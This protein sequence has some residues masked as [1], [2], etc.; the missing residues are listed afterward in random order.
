M[1]SRVVTET[2][3]ELARPAFSVSYDEQAFTAFLKERP[4]AHPAFARDLLLVHLFAQGEP[5]AMRVLEDE[6]F[7]QLPIVIGSIDSRRGFVEDAVQETKTKLCA[8]R[9]L[10]QY[11]GR[12]PLAGWIRRA[13][14]NTA[15]VLKRP[16]Q[17]RLEGPADELLANDTELVY[18]KTRF[19]DAFRA[20]FRDAVTALPT[21][22]RTA[23]RLNAIANVSIDELGVMYQVHRATA[24]RWIQRARQDILAGTLARIEERL[25][26]SPEEAEELMHTLRSQLDVSLRTLE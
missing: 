17:P 18:L 23:L 20:A 13:A 21:R 4:A 11:S 16:E 2:I 19:R 22:E 5:L 9:R 8:E 15:L 3:L 1:A 10:L 24:A 6:F 14:L 12:G 26:L 7:R 25:K